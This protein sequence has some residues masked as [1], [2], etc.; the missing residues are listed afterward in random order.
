A[1]NPDRHV[2]VCYA[3]DQ[4]VMD[5]HGGW[6]ANATDL[7]RFA[8][9]FADA[10]QPALLKPSSVQQMWAQPPASPPPVWYGMGWSVRD[11]GEGRHNAWHSGLL[12]G[13]TSTLLVRR[14]DGY[15]WAALFNTDRSRSNGK[16]LSG[17]VDPLIHGAISQVLRWNPKD[18]R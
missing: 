14:H 1:V 4:E 12:T 2:S 17:L 9:A 6:V 11:V 10:E 8:A 15:T 18:D 3:H 5:A 7:A 16:V 13:G